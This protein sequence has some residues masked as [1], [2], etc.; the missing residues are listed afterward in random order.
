MTAS[1]SDSLGSDIDGPGIHASHGDR[2][3]GIVLVT[4]GSGT[5]GALVVDRLRDHGHAV[6]VVSRRGS[7]PRDDVEYVSGDLDTGEGVA[8]AVAGVDLIV[9][10]AG[11]QKGDGEKARQLVEA[12]R[13]EGV[14]HLVYISVA[15]ADRVPVHSKTDHAMFE[16]FA[17]KRVGELVIE[18]SG[19]PFTTLRTTQ[20][21]TLVYPVAQSVAKL[22]I[23]PLP[24]RLHVQP[25]AAE[26]VADRL[27]ALAEGEPA[28]YV[29]EFGG[30]RVYD[31]HELV[32][33]YLRSVGRRRW[34]VSVSLPGKAAKAVLHDAIVSTGSERGTA[35]WEEYLAA[36]ALEP[37]AG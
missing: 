19:I 23:V 32:R 6:R 27:V 8:D 28:G 1:S 34:I 3:S 2:R 25:V 36:R 11:A 29:P 33:A 31:S 15:G 7:G 26:E 30:P 24:K 37:T 12:A 18:R 35:T 13:R 14:R 4:G 9:H 10:C 22:P 5:L 16:Y 20:F 21:F 17:Q